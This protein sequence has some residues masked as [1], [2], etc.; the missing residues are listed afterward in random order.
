MQRTARY[1]DLRMWFTATEAQEC[2]SH[3]GLIE[4]RRGGRYPRRGKSPCCKMHAIYA[5]ARGNKMR[6]QVVAVL[7]VLFFVGF[8]SMVAGESKYVNAVVHED[9]RTGAYIRYSI[10]SDGK[11]IGQVTARGWLHLGGAISEFEK[12][13]GI[14]INWSYRDINATGIFSRECKSFL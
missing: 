3:I 9:C 12:A 4:G 14:H 6:R 11:V 7:L 13:N 1:G 2:K 5:G 10:E 8:V